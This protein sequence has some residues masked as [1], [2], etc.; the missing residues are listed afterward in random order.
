MASGPASPTLRPSGCG[1]SGH[2]AGSRGAQGRGAAVWRPRPR[3][4]RWGGRCRPPQ[5][6]RAQARVLMAAL[7]EPGTHATDRGSD[8]GARCRSRAWLPAPAPRPP[9]G[10]RW[11]HGR[12]PTWHSRTGVRRHGGR[13]KASSPRRRAWRR[14][15]A[16][17]SA[18]T[19]AGLRK[20]LRHSPHRRQTPISSSCASIRCTARVA[21]A[22]SLAYP[23]LG[24]L[25]QD[26]GIEKVPH[27]A[28]LLVWR[29]VS[30]AWSACRRAR[31]HAAA[32]AGFSQPGTAT[33]CKAPAA[34]RTVPSLAPDIATEYHEEHPVDMPQTARLSSGG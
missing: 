10:G 13:P 8:T 32:E 33:S 25:K 16:R 29:S 22:R 14:R 21:G 23:T 31:T 1:G 26:V 19:A 20:T 2:R 7:P 3:R 12:S 15:S 9:P 4:A 27:H 5:P 18:A 24:V 6:C 28:P 34:A 17:R 30:R 11:W